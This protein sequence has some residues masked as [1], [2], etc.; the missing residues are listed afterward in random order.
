MTG[1]DAKQTNTVVRLTADPNGNR[2]DTWKEIAVYLGREVRTAQRWQK[3]EGLPVHRHFH[4]KASTVYAFKYEVDAWL[5]KRRWAAGEHPENAKMTEH[6]VDRLRPRTKREERMLAR[7]RSWMQNA[8][9]MGSIDLL[10]GENR[11]RLHFYV[12][13]REDRDVSSSVKHSSHPRS[14]NSADLTVSRLGTVP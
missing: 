4:A 5:Q 2:L 13:L 3:T 14:G 9:A 12:Q 1:M 8:T 10:Y 11:L 6:G 7:S